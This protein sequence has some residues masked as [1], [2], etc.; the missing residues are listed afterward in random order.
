MKIRKRELIIG[1]NIIPASHIDIT[2]EF[3]TS[4]TKLSP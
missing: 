3:A 4:L 1:P 2:T